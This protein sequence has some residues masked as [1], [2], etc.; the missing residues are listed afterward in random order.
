[1]NDENYGKIK[2]AAVVAM[3]AFV[4][5]R[6]YEIV[7]KSHRRYRHESQDLVTVEVVIDRE[8]IQERD[9]TQG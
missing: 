1:M 8:N 2:F 4:T 3:V 7:K 6:V 9:I 5:I